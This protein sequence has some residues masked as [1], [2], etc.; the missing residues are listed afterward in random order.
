MSLRSCGTFFFFFK[1][2][3]TSCLYKGLWRCA[4]N[5][6]LGIAHGG[7]HNLKLPMRT[8]A[9]GQR[10]SEAAICCS[11]KEKMKIRMFLCC[12]G[13]AESVKKHDM[14]SQNFIFS[15]R[16][17]EKVASPSLPWVFLY[18]YE[19]RIATAWVR[20]RNGSYSES[21]IFINTRAFMWFGCRDVAAWHLKDLLS[22]KKGG[23]KNG[24]L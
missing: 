12:G 21:K 23:R 13:T 19:G 24:W 18:A 11:L 15:Y 14:K 4:K 22:R 8:A 17:F 3:V 20:R 16:P 9:V 6:L 10:L 1:T 2:T 5:G 7:L